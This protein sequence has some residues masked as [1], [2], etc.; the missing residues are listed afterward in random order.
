MRKEFPNERMNKEME[1][2]SSFIEIVFVSVRMTYSIITVR[3]PNFNGGRELKPISNP[4][5]VFPL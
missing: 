2:V 4:P 3:N 5:L 1:T